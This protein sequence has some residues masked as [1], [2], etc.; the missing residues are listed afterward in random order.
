MWADWLFGMFRT[1]PASERHR[2]LTFILVPLDTRVSPC[3][4]FPNWTG[5]RVLPKCFRRCRSGGG[6]RLGEEGAGWQVA[7]ATAGFERG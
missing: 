2:G 6:N 3:D 1:D 7:M 4:P 5:C